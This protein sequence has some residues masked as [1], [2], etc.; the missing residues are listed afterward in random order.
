VSDFDPGILNY[1]EGLFWTVPVSSDDV[2]VDLEDGTASLHVK[3]LSAFDFFNIPNALFRTMNPVNIPATVSFKLDWLGPITNRVTLINTEHRFRG[4]FLTNHARMEWSAHRADGFKFVSDSASTSTS[5][6][7]EI[8]R[9]R[10][11]VFF[12]QSPDEQDSNSD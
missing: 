1:P 10:N 9:D 8:G 4:T 6:F 3:R 5:V 7:S 11:G 2:H 12:S